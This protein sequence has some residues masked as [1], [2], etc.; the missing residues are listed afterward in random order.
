MADT[1][2]KDLVIVGGGPAGLTAAIY[3]QRALLDSITLEQE[4]F[5][6]QV[7]LTNEI[8][9]Y[10]GVPNTDGYTLSEAMKNQAVDLGAEVATGRPTGLAVNEDGSFT[11]TT[12]TDTY[13][14]KT[15]IVAAGAKP[16]LA[17]F[18]GEEAFRGFGV[19]YCATCDGMFFRNKHVFVIGGGNS[20]CEEALFLTKFASKVSLIVRKDHVRAHA[21]VL[22]QLED[23][24]K[25]EIRYLTSVVKVE[26][27]NNKLERITLRH[28]D[29]NE[30]YT[31][32]FEPAGFGVFVFVGM[33]PQTELVK[34]LVDL[35]EAGYALADER[36]VTKTPGLFVAG[37]MVKKPLRQI[38]TA[39]ADGAIAATSAAGYLGAPVEG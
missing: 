38:I 3:A 29:T 15:V 34:D 37:D 10:P 35:D 4:S 19:S 1:H 22:K 8:D 28:N 33:N 36:M 16:R 18:E 17:G 2:T 30:E 11:I 26:G 7:M 13:A 20:A 14:A 6:G 12:D 27:D 5:G 31:E 39:A 23:N 25:I 24:E 21:I 32:E 9:N